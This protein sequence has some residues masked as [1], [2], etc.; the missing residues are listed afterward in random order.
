VIATTAGG[1]AE[2]ITAG[3]TSYTASPANAPSLAAAIQRAHR[4]TRTARADA[5]RGRRL[6]ASRYDY[7]V[8]VFLTA[9]A[10][11][12]IVTAQST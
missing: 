3:H 4:H 8:R 12:A 7:D 6:I 10:P 1:L 11:W 9:H 2:L 5:R